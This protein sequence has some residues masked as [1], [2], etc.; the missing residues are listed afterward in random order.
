MLWFP[1]QLELLH[2]ESRKRLE[3]ESDSKK[4]QDKLVDELH[5]REKELQQTISALQGDKHRLEDTIYRIKAEAMANT[6]ALKQMEEKVEQE[7]VASVSVK[8]MVVTL[9]VWGV[10]VLKF[11]TRLWLV[12]LLF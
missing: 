2:R 10:Y 12:G 7:K 4:N 11:S 8:H 3:S 9:R 1:L 5:A 6:V